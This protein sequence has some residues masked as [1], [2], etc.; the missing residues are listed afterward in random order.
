MALLQGAETQRHLHLALRELR[1]FRES[2]GAGSKG[3]DDDHGATVLVSAA[4]TLEDFSDAVSVSEC[5]L[6]GVPDLPRQARF[7][8]S[9]FLFVSSGLPGLVPGVSGAGVGG[10]FASGA[11]SGCGRSL[12]FSVPSQRSKTEVPFS[13]FM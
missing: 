1:C 7:S 10:A 4:A 9:A 13:S 6:R 11:G 5:C 2:P 12:D 3:D 8:P